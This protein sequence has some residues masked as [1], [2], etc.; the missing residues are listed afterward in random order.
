MGTGSTHASF[1][2]LH[3]LRPDI[4]AR[5]HADTTLVLAMLDATADIAEPHRALMILLCVAM[6]AVLRDA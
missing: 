6:E 3:A 2:A 1:Q 5:D 4:A